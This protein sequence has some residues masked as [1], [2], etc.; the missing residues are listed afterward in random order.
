MM[1]PY[2]LFDILLTLIYQMP[3]QVFEDDHWLF[4][5]IGFGRIWRI[6]PSVLIL[7]QEFIPSEKLTLDLPM[8]LLKGVILEAISIYI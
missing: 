3:F 1:F 7:G 2:L 8:L 5:T 6:S 4:H